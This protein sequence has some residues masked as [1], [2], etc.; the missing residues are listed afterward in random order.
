M[1][2]VNLAQLLTSPLAEHRV[3]N[4]LS[5]YIESLVDLTL[6]H[7]LSRKRNKFIRFSDSIQ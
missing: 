3:G 7:P 2:D 4:P 1:K 5:E 6:P